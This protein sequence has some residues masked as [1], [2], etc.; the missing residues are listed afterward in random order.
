MRDPQFIH[1]RDT[2]SGDHTVSNLGSEGQGSFR[3]SDAPRQARWGGD[4]SRPTPPRSAGLLF[5]L[6]LQELG[7]ERNV[8]DGQAEGLD[9]GQPLLISEGGHLPAQLVEGLV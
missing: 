2:A 4:V 8:D 5:L 9:P 6:A 1:C 3:L 7:H